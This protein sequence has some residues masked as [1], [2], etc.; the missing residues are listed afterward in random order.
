MDASS[1]SKVEDSVLWLFK[2]NKWVE[3]NLQQEAEKRGVANR[4]VFAK[5]VIHPL[6]L[7]RQKLADIFVDTFNVNAGVTIGDALL[8][9]LPVVTK[10][11]KGMPARVGGMTLETLNMPELIT[12]NEL[13]YEA[14]L[15]ELATKPKR[16]SE[17]K[18]KLA[19]NRL[20][21][22]LFNTK[23]FTKNIENGYQQAYQQY[24]DKKRPKNIIVPK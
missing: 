8:A 17:I 4:L 10:L 14:L 20:T 23:L 16:L 24:F 5:K 6:H 22:P 2:S 13:E 9:G 12:K 7:A 3:K 19:K 15:L 18:E 11:G 1:K 21:T